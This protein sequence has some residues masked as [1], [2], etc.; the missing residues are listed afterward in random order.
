MQRILFA[1]ALVVGAVVTYVDSRPTWDDTGVTV[2]ALFL[3]AG[4]L[5]FLGPRRPWLWALALGVWIPLLAVVR[6]R[7]YA[8]MLALVVALAGAYAGAAVRKCSS[9]AERR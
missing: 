8:A 4:A 2:T 9:P 7:N 6:T 3:A 1:V 5:G